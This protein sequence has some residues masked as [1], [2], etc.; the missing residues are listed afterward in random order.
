MIAS[1]TAF[2]RLVV[3]LLRRATA[4]ELVALESLVEMV[5]I[6]WQVAAVPVQGPTALIQ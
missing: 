5:I 1:F 6:L 4:E 2:L 3:A